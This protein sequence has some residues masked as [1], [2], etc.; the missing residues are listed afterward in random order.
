MSFFDV[1]L[2]PFI[3]FIEQV[4][5]LAYGLTNNH[6]LSIVLLSFAVSLI[7][8]PV[9]ILIEKAKKRDDAKKQRMKPL[10]DEIK[11]C[12]RGQERYYYLK[13]LNRQ[14]GY[15]PLKALL[16][17]L[18][19]LLQIPFFIAAYQFLEGYAP[20]AGQSFL[21]I[22]D[23]SAP[24]GLLG[25]VNVLPIAMTLVNLLTAYFYTRN[26]RT[27][28]LNQMLVVALLFLILLFN[29]P[30]GLVLYW[31]MNNVFSFFRLFI[32]N[33]E[34]FSKVQDK[35][36]AFIRMNKLKGL[37]VN[38]LKHFPKAAIVFVIF[39]VGLV[40]SQI[41]W[42]FKYNFDTIVI[43]II[44]SFFVSLF[45][46]G[47][48]AIVFALAKEKLVLG[49]ALLV[50]NIRFYFVALFLALY[51]LLAA[52]FYFTGTN[53]SL[54]I[55]AL[56]LVAILEIVSIRSMLAYKAV[57]KK[58]I[59]RL[60][61]FGVV[62]FAFIQLLC[63]GAIFNGGDF[64]FKILSLNLKAQDITWLNFSFI[65]ILIIL[66]CSPAIF[67]KKYE[68]SYSVIQKQGWLVFILSVFYILGLIFFWNPM[69]VY[70]SYP[71][72]FD[73]PAISILTNNLVFFIA[74]TSGLLLIY[75]VLPIRFRPVAIVVTL[76]I[77]VVTLLYSSIIPFDVGVLNVNHFSNEKNLAKGDLYYALEVFLLV[78]VYFIVDWVYRRFKTVYIVL[79]IGLLNL[80]VIGQS[81]Y[82]TNKTGDLFVKEIKEVNK[83][84]GKPM[85]SFSK[86]HQNIV[87]FVI[88]GAQGW[89]MHDYISEDERYG[90]DFAGFT[91]YPNT[92][93]M[94]NYTYASVPSI[95]CGYKYSIPN[96]NKDSSRTIIQKVSDATEEFYEKI[97]GGGYELT[98]TVMR[99]SSIDH[100]KF[101]T[102]IP[103]WHD[104]W[105][106]KLD[107]DEP[108]EMW[109]T[110]LWENAVFSSVPLFL[111]PKIYNNT[112]WILK[113]KSNLNLSELNEYNF[114]RVLPKISNTASERPNFIY[115][116][117]LYTHNP[118][119]MIDED[120]NFVRG[121]T[122][123]ECQRA[124]TNSFVKWLNWMK[125][126]GVYDNTKIILTSDHGPSWW[127]FNGEIET[128]APIV[129]TKENKISLERF[130]HLNALL[131][132]KDYNRHNSLKTDWRLMN[133][134]D[135]SA[136]AF[137]INDP[138]KADSTYRSTQTFFTVWHQDL[139]TRVKYELKH[140]FEIENYVYDL[141]NWTSIKED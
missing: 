45:F 106:E 84:S 16:P 23:L 108:E 58:S 90:D 140:A 72:N 30:S 63:A 28:E 9:F 31:T 64:S 129:W 121:V 2:S 29:L 133:T 65:G 49:R 53:D 98:S 93:A 85:I 13:T 135:V 6:G 87:V 97:K 33:K 103:H 111:K 66:I 110:R 62:V 101:D 70:S 68:Y 34:V 22:D 8:L 25:R 132:V 138:T 40:A 14:H 37:F 73:F 46:G 100:S 4:Y 115:I 131:M 19:L 12:Y 32:T 92:V 96:M 24:D 81:F 102:H 95:M 76:Y 27:S 48:T 141:N 15:S 139:R 43:R 50:T 127:H 99:Y 89:Y 117:S 11:R 105:S 21:F 128:N 94:A 112:R 74:I 35:I 59:F 104:T 123:S 116:H 20:L 113:Q 55:I 38:S 56:I 134:A 69:I 119:N 42:A 120:N 82:L 52:S 130:L 71:A 88:D 44:I 77:C 26:G 61:V 54:L 5:A 10:A 86:H 137:D 118:W 78:G 79:S 91:Y 57:L 36:V 122:P 114:V 51:F 136:I 47:I 125:D 41:N 1:L 107:L 80:L 109:Y 75:F 83:D 17:L 39:F 18:S 3:Y 126:N 124:F 60:L 67:K 7:L